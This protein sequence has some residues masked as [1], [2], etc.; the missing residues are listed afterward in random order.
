MKSSLALF[1]RL[2]CGFFFLL[3]V[4]LGSLLFF[5]SRMPQNPLLRNSM[6]VDGIIL[7]IETRTN[8]AQYTGRYI[9]SENIQ[10]EY[11]VDGLTFQ[12]WD[13]F[14]YD[15][16]F[17]VG[18]T[19]SIIYDPHEPQNAQIARAPVPPVDYTPALLVTGGVA[20]LGAALFM[21]RPGQKQKRKNEE[22]HS[23]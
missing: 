8:T 23:L 10:F 3:G 13:S 16:D 12:A 22:K 6:R 4:F 1:I 5:A 2:G 7:H 21:R 15:T 11:G 18:Q 9:L 20:A 17:H 19:I 14:T